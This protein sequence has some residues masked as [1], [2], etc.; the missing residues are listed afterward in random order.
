[1][2]D[3]YTGDL[4]DFGKYGLLKAL[5]NPDAIGAGDELS[6]GVVWYLVPDEQGTDDPDEK[7]TD[8]GKHTRYLCPSPSNDSHFRSCDPDLY[9]KLAAIVQSESRRVAQIR[10]RKILPKQTVFYE[11]RL[12]FDGLPAIGPAAREARLARRGVW[13]RDAQDAVRRRD[14]VFVDPDN[15]LEGRTRCYHKRGPK[16]AYLDELGPY[17]ARGQSLIIYQHTGRSRSAVQQVEARLSQIGR[18]L[19][20]SPEPFALLYH[21]GTSRAFL[22]V[23]AE[24]HKK[25]LV[26][27]AERLLRGP[28]AR[29]FTGPYAPAPGPLAV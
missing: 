14:V 7:G 29:H 8:D 9:A 11:A 19:Q 10:Q 23:P 20:T 15:G 1:M 22:I 16:F 25:V 5:C 28:W 18:R 4:G 6:L 27:R 13:V 3:R 26:E 21:R 2:Q 17:I 24:R 12:T